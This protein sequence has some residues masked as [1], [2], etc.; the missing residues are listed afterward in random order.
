MEKQVSI[1]VA[2][3]GTIKDIAISPGATVRDILQENLILK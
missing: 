3:T 1:V 2:A